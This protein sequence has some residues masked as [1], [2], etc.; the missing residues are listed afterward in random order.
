VGATL[1][2]AARILAASRRRECMSQGGREFIR[3]GGASALQVEYWGLIAGKVS[4]IILARFFVG[5]TTRKVEAN[6]LP[7]D[8]I[9]G[10][11]RPLQRAG[12]GRSTAEPVANSAEIFIQTEAAIRRADASS[13]RDKPSFGSSGRE[14]HAAT[15]DPEKIP[16]KIRPRDDPAQRSAVGGFTS[17]EVEGR[18]FK[19]ENVQGIP[20]QR[21]LLLAARIQGVDMAGKIE[22][23]QEISRSLLPQLSSR[24]PIIRMDSS[25]KKKIP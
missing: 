19:R 25:S 9:P 21:L 2:A 24:S 20:Q 4:A 18:K 12:L 23:I 10:D 1:R 3:V 17:K 13:A 5:W 6:V 16:R 15:C 22:R 7:G 14:I 11:A 8:G